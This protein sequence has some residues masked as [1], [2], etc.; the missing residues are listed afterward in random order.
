LIQKQLGTTANGLT[1]NLLF[2]KNIVGAEPS[3]EQEEWGN[4]TYTVDTDLT[5]DRKFTIQF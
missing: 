2:D 4:T 5:V 1:L 3:E